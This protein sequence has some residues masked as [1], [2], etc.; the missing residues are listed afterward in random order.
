MATALGK[1]V[2]TCAAGIAGVLPVPVTSLV[3]CKI[4]HDL[5]GP[6]VFAVA[7]PVS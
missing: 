4:H 7:E 5:W 1:T 2:G 3:M 6:F